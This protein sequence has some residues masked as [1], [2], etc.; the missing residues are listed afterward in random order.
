M[1]R[2]LDLQPVMTGGQ[3]KSLR[4]QLL[5][6]ADGRLIEHSTLVTC[7]D[8][9]KALYLKANDYKP[10]TDLSYRAALRGLKLMEFTP[11]NH[12]RRG[13][14]QQKFVGRDLLLGWMGG[15]HPEWEDD[16]R[17]GH[18]DNFI[19]AMWL[20][21]LLDDFERAMHEH[22]PEYWRFH[23]AAAQQ[24]LRPEGDRLKTLCKV[25][26]LIIHEGIEQWDR[27]TKH[28]FV[29]GTEAFS[30][31]T[32][33]HNIIFGAHD[34]GRNVPGTLSCLSALGEYVGGT[35]CFPR[36]GV[37]F[38]LRPGDLLIADTNEEYH[39]TVDGIIGDRYSVV[40]YL[41]G[42]LVTK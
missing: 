1:I 22:L 37:S 42:S 28:Y 14:V 36:L 5:T 21:P 29:P 13:A 25:K 18:R 30:T 39:G 41:H 3:L 26:N 38:C 10:I 2:R 34:D 40:A 9:V 12:S 16:F 33:N 32:L 27:Q 31:I 6:A 17:A 19:P 8:T 4:F 11:A 15:R 24:L 35:L 23:M 20:K 7:E